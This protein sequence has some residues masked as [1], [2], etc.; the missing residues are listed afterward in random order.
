LRRLVVQRLADEAVGHPAAGV[1]RRAEEVAA[2]PV[3]GV[4]AL[5]LPSGVR[6]TAR[7]GRLTFGRTPKGGRGSG[8]GH[9]DDTTRGAAPT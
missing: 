1:A 2:M 9:G 8:G 3:S 7:D 5:D 4:S 6:A